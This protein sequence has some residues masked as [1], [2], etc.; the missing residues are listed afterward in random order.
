MWIVLCVCFVLGPRL[1]LR[2]AFF[3][4]FKQDSPVLLGDP[5]GRPRQ[6]PLAS[7]WEKFLTSVGAELYS[8][9]LHVTALLLANA[10]RCLLAKRSCC[11]W[12]TH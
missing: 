11:C 7:L 10:K 9:Y 8:I 3:A 2:F 1:G 4:G 5:R 6:L 12:R